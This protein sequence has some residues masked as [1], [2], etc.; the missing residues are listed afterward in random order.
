LRAAGKPTNGDFRLR[1][2]ND[3]WGCAGDAYSQRNDDGYNAEAK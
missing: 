3:D 2:G 1:S